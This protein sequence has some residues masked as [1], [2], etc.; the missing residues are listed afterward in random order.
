MN[1]PRVYVCFDAHG[2]KNPAATDLKYYFLLRA[3]GRRAPLAR[4]FI[5]VHRSAPRFC[6]DSGD[7]RRALAKRLH[8]SD[9]VL[10]IL[11]ERTP[12]TAGWVSWEIDFATQQC[13]LPIVCA[14]PGRD[15]IDAQEGH[16]PWWPGALQRLM[17]E[18]RV[19]AL[20]VPFRPRALA[21][22]F[23]RFPHPP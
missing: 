3:W 17:S 18:K 11:S 7:I 12:V 4:T 16:R 2:S 15:V 10:L 13:G 20:H 23:A 22:A 9:L 1:T 19:H 8:D 6:P 5:D 14:Y 21:R